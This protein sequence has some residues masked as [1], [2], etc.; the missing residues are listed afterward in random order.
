MQDQPYRMVNE[1]NDEIDLRELIRSLWDQRWIIVGITA[2]V[3]L[4]AVLY[5]FLATPYYRV[6]S[7]LR[8]VEVGVL[9][10]LNATEVY[11]LKPL[12]ALARV[13]GG[14][15]S[16]GNRLEFFQ[17]N[18]DLFADLARQELTAEQAFENFNSEAFAMLYPDP[19][20][21][22]GEFVG[23]ALTYPASMDGVSVVNEFVAFVLQRERERVASDLAVVIANRK[24]NIE[25]RIEAARASYQAGKEA[26]IAA[27]LEKAALKKAEL[28]DELRALRTELKIRRENRLSVLE[29]AIRIARSLGIRKPTTPTAMA[30]AGQ[31]VR[32]EITSREIP[33]YFLGVDALEAEREVLRARTSDDFMEPRIGEIQKELDMLRHNRQVEVLQQRQDEDLYLNELAKLREEA[34]RLE[35]IEFDASTLQ[36]A[37]IDQPAQK[38]LKRLKPKRVLILAL[39]VVLGGMLGVFV[40]LMRNL[41]QPRRVR[42]AN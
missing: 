20:K 30:D 2:F 15:S 42:P 24:A 37:R 41:M 22:Q 28:E 3:T 26:E 39:G 40:A 12:E 38:P 10:S 36:L 16:Y 13:S 25:Q 1:N 23:L 35:G 29:E 7:I 32:T 8:P 4:I 17:G 5:A 9:D 11:E 14:L 19:K 27:L 33:L 31:G 6:Q 34:A 21:N 18:E